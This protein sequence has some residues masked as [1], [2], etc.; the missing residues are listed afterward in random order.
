M[1]HV[2]VCC[3]RHLL[4]ALF[5]CFT[6]GLAHAGPPSGYRFLGFEEAVKA[7]RQQNRPVFVYFG[8]MGCPWCDRT[9]QESF[10]D[11]AVREAYHA[12]FVLAY[13]DTESTQRV[14]LPSGERI[15]EM[16]LSAR[17]RVVATPFF[18]FVDPDLRTLLRVP[19]YKTAQEFRDYAQFIAG[20]HYRS[21]TLSEFLATRK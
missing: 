16:D 18:V 15:S 20:G 19:G 6:L 8:R 7:A 14:T 21:Q 4:F 11:A 13:V 12:H 2:I 1:S 3:V 9:N 17:Y 10:S 5:C